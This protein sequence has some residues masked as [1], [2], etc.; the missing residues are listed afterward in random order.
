MKQLF[1]LFVLALAV[2]LVSPELVA[3]GHGPVYGLATPTLGKGGWSLDAAIMVRSEEG[4]RES[5]M[6]RPMVG[7]GITEDLQLSFSV[8]VPLYREE[9]L[10]PERAMA[11]M[12]GTPDMEFMVN[13]RFHR[14]GTD[15]GARFEST[16]FFGLEYPTDAVRAGVRTSPGVLG[17]VVT[18][19]ASRSIYAWAGG[20]YQRSMSPRGTTADHIGD[21]GMVSLVFGYRPHVFRQELPHPDWRLFVEAIGEWRQPDVRNGIELPNRGGEQVFIGPTVLGL[22]GPWGISGG[23]VFPVYSD[24]NGD[25]PEENYR[26][27]VNFTYWF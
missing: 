17:G 23:P 9:G 5:V 24:L 11:M 13:W 25:Q 15:V 27:V 8:P 21:L 19:Y 26:F 22:Y 10:Q 20:L 14:E 16:A 6:A 7:Y 1:S 12:P 4:D 3:S 18:G 2:I